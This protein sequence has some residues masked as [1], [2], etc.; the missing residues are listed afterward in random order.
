[1]E[2]QREAA[3]EAEIQARGAR[4]LAATEPSGPLIPSADWLQERLMSWASGDPD[5][6][7][8]LLRFVD[9]L[10]TLR[11]SAA[12]A[13]HVRQYFGGT[14]HVSVR[15]GVGAAGRRAFR[16]LLSQAV[17]RGVFAMSG[18]FIGGADA[19]EAI[20]RLDPL[21]E[22][23]VACTFDILGEAT[24]SD[25]EAEAYASRYLELLDSLAPLGAAV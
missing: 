10:P 18:R 8:R 15:M 2:A 12:V 25:L 11:T 17:R 14:P 3:A 16:P 20:T 7:T 19:E 24:L 4:L 9:V 23:G 5:F 21:R 22:Q 6:R 1:M 13:D